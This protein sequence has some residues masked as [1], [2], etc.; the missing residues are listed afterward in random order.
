MQSE[1]L[2]AL[3]TGLG[4]M[5]GWGLADFFAKKT[6]DEIG[7]MAS[8]AWGHI[9]GTLALFL[10]VAHNVFFFERKIVMPSDTYTW[11][12][13]IFFGMLQATVYFFLY[14]GFGKGQVSLLSPIFASFAGITAIMSIVFFREAVNIFLIFALIII[15]CGSDIACLFMDI[16]LGKIG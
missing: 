13:L 15:F 7:D 16:I 5:L 6:I 8:L 11:I 9:F 2:I 14:R 4:G 10:A 12:I 1:L 3:L